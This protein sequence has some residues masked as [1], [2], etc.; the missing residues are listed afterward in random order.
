LWAL[1]HAISRHR[2]VMIA[3]A[4]TDAAMRIVY[5]IMLGIFFAVLFAHKNPSAGV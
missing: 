5:P 1:S 2:R 3:L 4:K